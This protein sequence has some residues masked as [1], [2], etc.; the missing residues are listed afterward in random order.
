MYQKK[1]K[2]LFTLRFKSFRIFLVLI[3]LAVP[4]LPLAFVLRGLKSIS[5]GL[6]Y[7]KHI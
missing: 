6:R 4:P 1:K 5:F 2:K 3:T 7:Y